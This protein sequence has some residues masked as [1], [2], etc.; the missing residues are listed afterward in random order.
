[1]LGEHCSNKFWQR[2]RGE[3]YIAQVYERAVTS[4]RFT[5]L[6]NLRYSVIKSDL[7][8]NRKCVLTAILDVVTRTNRTSIKLSKRQ[9]IE[10][11]GVSNQTVQTIMREFRDLNIIQDEHRGYFRVNHI[12]LDAMVET[13]TVEDPEQAIAEC[14][15]FSDVMRSDKYKETHER[16]RRKHKESQKAYFAERIARA[17][18]KTA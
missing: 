1:M 13:Q 8:R 16:E 12:V 15:A 14:R 5:Y 4:R 9:I 11:S 7:K 18:R 6:L 3:R 10:A 2:W 17:E